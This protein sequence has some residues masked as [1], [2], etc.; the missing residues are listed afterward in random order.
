MK[1]SVIL[2]SATALL[3][4][5][6]FFVGIIVRPGAVPPETRI[7]VDTS[8]PHGEPSVGII[9]FISGNFPDRYSF[10]YAELEAALW[11][12]AELLALGFDA[13]WIQPFYYRDVRSDW[14]LPLFPALSILNTTPFANLGLRA[15][16]GSQN[17]VLTLPGQSSQTIIVGA[18]YD[19]VFVPGASDNASGAALLM[20]SASRM[21]EMEHYYTIT[22][23][24]FGAEEAG[25]FGAW[26]Y[27]SS[28]NH[29]DVIFMINAD[30]LLEGP[31][32]FYMA[33]YDTAVSPGESA[34]EHWDRI[35]S[36]INGFGSSNFR[37]GA[38]DITEA[39]GQL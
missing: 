11:I 26:Y 38:N 2:I 39:W 17:V 6:V 33:G 36:G 18:H 37:P 5:A 9:E 34:D 4:I 16:R 29:D 15:D 20:E 21:R 12:Y 7:G 13:A 23:V 1:E 27:A 24:F 30:V 32:L 3:A 19:G 25:L 10:S 31:Y 8:A 35:S 28:I 14:P 22:Y